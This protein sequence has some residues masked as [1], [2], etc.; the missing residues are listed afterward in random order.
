ML[1]YLAQQLQ[2]KELGPKTLNKVW[3]NFGKHVGKRQTRNSKKGQAVWGELKTSVGGP[4]G[5]LYLSS[6]P[7]E[8]DDANK[9]SLNKGTETRDN[10][11]LITT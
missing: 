11:V 9:N 7:E 1:Q 5:P 3:P 4:Q 6:T 2:W 8:G 10:T